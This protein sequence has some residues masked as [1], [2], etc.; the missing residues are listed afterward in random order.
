MNSIHFYISATVL[1]ASAAICCIWNYVIHIKRLTKKPIVNPMNVFSVSVF[2]A[3]LI[4]FIPT[5][6]NLNGNFAIALISSFMDSIDSI[7]FGNSLKDM[8]ARVFGNI[9]NLLSSTSFTQ[10]FYVS[11][12]YVLGPVLGARAVFLIFRDSFTQLRCL[13]NIKNNLHIF[14]ELSEKSIVAAKDIVSENKNTKI[15]FCSVGNN[16]PENS[17]IERARTINALLTKKSIS[18]FKTGNGISFGK[19]YLYFIGKDEKNN[20]RLALDKVKSIEKTKKDIDLLVFSSQE[21]AEYVIDIANK[22]SANKHIRIDLFDEAQRTA[23]NLVFEHPVC[24]VEEKDE[25]IN[26]MVLGMGNYGLAFAKAVS[27]C[28]QMM[29]RKFDIKLFDKQNKEDFTGFPFA[30]LSTKLKKIGTE[31]NTEFVV[32]DVFSEQFNYFR[33]K[34]TDYILIALGEDELNL[35]AALLMR[36]LYSRKVTESAFAV[37]DETAPRII[38]H[39]QNAETK[40]IVQ[41]LNDP[42][43]IPYGTLE[44]VF[45]GSNI[46]NWKIDR[47][48]EFIHACYYCHSRQIFKL[49]SEAERF[50]AFEEGMFDYR[51]QNE[52]NKRSSRATAVHGKYKFYDMGIDP[53]K[54]KLLSKETA[55]TVDS[56]G[57]KLL[58][59]E[60]NRW[61]VFQM[62]D[63]WEPWDKNTLI[64]NTHK[65]TTAKLH[66]YLAEFDEL[67]PIA[68]FIYGEGADPVEYDR[69]ITDSLR[70]AYMYGIYEANLKEIINEYLK[71]QEERNG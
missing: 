14:S 2:A 63:D 56:Y 6:N 53:S 21:S 40:K 15:I 23:Y 35:K 34:K 46:F 28:S 9:E 44:D 1:F 67:K 71:F 4:I 7:S 39:I 58:R 55:D 64:K 42:H 68:E 13:F 26:I 17:L 47:I 65:N 51:K 31:L 10:R 20:V 66:S 62:L 5:A 37:S 69:I 18:G 45:K 11:I 59:A 48:A 19:T 36:K 49:Q 43:L 16:I 57:E 32:C 8:N 38:I 50:K 24:D 29:N 3:L 60:H 25:K 70:F 61:N 41:A 12:L 33:F 54:E 27:W 30:E 52:L 22:S